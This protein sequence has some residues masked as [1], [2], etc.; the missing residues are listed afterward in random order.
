MR[1]SNPTWIDE[2]EDDLK[3][4]GI[5]NR[6]AVSKDRQ[7]WRKIVLEVKVHNGL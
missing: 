2:V 1:T 5:R 6:H 7:E 3:I 4:M